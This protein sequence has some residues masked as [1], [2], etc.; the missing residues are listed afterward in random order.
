MS[1]GPVLCSEPSHRNTYG[2]EFIEK[3]DFDYES[4]G[5][6]ESTLGKMLGASSVH[7][8]SSKTSL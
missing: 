6:I 4:V 7:T 5:H 8:C 3:N 1:Q 2:V